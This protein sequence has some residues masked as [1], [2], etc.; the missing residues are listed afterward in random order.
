MSQLGNPDAVYDT[1][2]TARGVQRTADTAKTNIEMLLR[3]IDQ[4]QL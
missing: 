2:E 4:I 1:L 3:S